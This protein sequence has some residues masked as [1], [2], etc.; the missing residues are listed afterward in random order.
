MSKLGAINGLRGIAILAVIYHHLFSG[1]TGPGFGKIDFGTLPVLPLSPLAN[2]W[3]GVN[4]FFVLSGF[5][6]ALPYFSGQRTMANR[7]D[8]GDYYRRRAARLLPLYYFCVLVSIIFVAKPLDHREFL[9]EAMIM[10][11]V[12]F[13]FTTDMWFPRPNWVLWSLG[14]EIW[15][16]LLFP[17][18]LVAVE[19]YGI[20]RV[21][22]VTLIGALI[23][24]ILGNAPAFDIGNPYLNPLKDSLIGR[25]D[26]FVVGMY[27]A[28]RIAHRDSYPAIA[29][30]RLLLGAALALVMMACMLWDYVAL[31]ILPR[32]IAPFINTILDAGLLA[33]VLAALHLPSGFLRRCFENYC[34]QLLGVMCYSLYVWHG[35]AIGKI[36][37]AADAVNVIR[38]LILVLLL[39]GLSYRFIE[40]GHVRDT[41]RLFLR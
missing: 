15:F 8:A 36:I 22:W 2:G 14:I 28:H 23:C 21:L 1:F 29:R 20:R 27:A 30:P 19:R 5:V 16:S 11:G 17:L 4:L 9:Y 38:Y 32:S 37:T 34:L 33:L 41:R 6:L 3:L 31:A 13:N 7:S 26:D 39:A 24:R 25:L 18:I 10:A 40:F 12:L 35:I